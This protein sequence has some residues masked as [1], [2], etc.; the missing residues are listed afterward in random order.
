MDE[1]SLREPSYCPCVSKVLGSGGPER[2][3]L[4]DQHSL[5][6]IQQ[7]PQH[8]PQGEAVPVGPTGNVL[9]RKT[10]GYALSRSKVTN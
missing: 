10:A 6:D 8:L 1:K 9:I 4:R 2:S 3:V 7:G 5:K